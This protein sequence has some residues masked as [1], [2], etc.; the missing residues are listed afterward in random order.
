MK[1]KP[2]KSVANVMFIN[3]LS[4]DGLATDVNEVIRKCD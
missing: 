1:E 4:W 3:Y 2:F